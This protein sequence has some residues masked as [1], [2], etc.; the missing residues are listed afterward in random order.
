MEKAF[1]TRPGFFPEV[2]LSKS[3]LF[4]PGV[5]SAGAK[6]PRSAAGAGE[7]GCP[8]MDAAADTFA[9]ILSAAAPDTGEAT[10]EGR[11]GSFYITWG[12]DLSCGRVGRSGGRPGA[13]TLQSRCASLPGWGGGSARSSAHNPAPFH[14]SCRFGI[15]FGRVRLLERHHRQYPLSRYADGGGAGI[16]RPVE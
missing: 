11:W 7:A 1:R 14:Q 10:G 8:S 3:F 4:P 2:R 13:R 6:L 16:F 9:R 5:R 15:R 12:L